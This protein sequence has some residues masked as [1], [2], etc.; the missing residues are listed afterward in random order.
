[1]CYSGYHRNCQLSLKRLKSALPAIALI[2]TTLSY[3]GCHGQ[4][5]G[6]Q[7]TA[8]LR[9]CG[10]GDSIKLARFEGTKFIF[11]DTLPCTSGS[12]IFSGTKPLKPGMYAL[13]PG[14]RGKIDL[15]ISDSL[16][17]KFSLSADVRQL[18]TTLS[19]EN[20]PE[21]SGYTDFQRLLRKQS[22]FR[23]RLYENQ[24]NPD[25]VNRLS[26]T[27]RQLNGELV[28]R[29]A[30]LLEQHT[31]KLLALF[32]RILKEPA[33]PE[34]S[35]P[36]MVTD[37]DRYIQEYY[38][39]YRK[40]HFWDGI[41]FSD[42]RLITLPVY[43][44]KLRY[45]FQ[46]LV[47]PAPEAAEQALDDVL[48]KAGA[49]EEVYRFTAYALFRLF[50][51]SP[52]SSLIPVS[53]HIADHYILNRQ[54][55]WKGD[56]RFAEISQKVA[57][58]R[59]NPPGSVAT[60]LKLVRN[61]GEMVKLSEIKARFTILYFFNPDC[62]SCN[63]ITEKLLPLYRR[64][65]NRGVEV[66]AVYLDNKTDIWKT[67]IASKK[68]DWI[69]VCDPTGA[70]GIESKYDIYAIPMIYVLDQDKKIIARDVPVEE[71]ESYFGE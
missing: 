6:H 67:Y 42:P 34:P 65:K 43:E 3:S 63:P 55:L 35:V 29:S 20:S 49:Q 23:G 39:R 18:S 57:K 19:F 27:L 21:N 10:P 22:E 15:L 48:E 68:L 5:T 54:E 47:E 41:D 56:P 28:S 46:Q 25:S 14:N 59:L 11:L 66:F 30:R 62:E 58:A 2:F 26:N 31:G 69:N 52:M 24:Q 44:E 38:F 40:E 37:R 64:A 32:L 60:D 4:Q 45:Y 71:L 16:N 50:R 70:E 12:A 9:G 33:A 8:A 51:E 13:F 1:M 61:S 36:L 7:I 53:V 17:Q